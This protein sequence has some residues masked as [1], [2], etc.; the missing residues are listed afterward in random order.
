M[1]KD[2]IKMKVYYEFL[3]E[4]RQKKLRTRPTNKLELYRR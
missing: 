1:L 3:E 2:R 4:I